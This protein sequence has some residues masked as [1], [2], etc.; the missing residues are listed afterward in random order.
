[1][2]KLYRS[3]ALTPADNS[4]ISNTTYGTTEAD[5][6]NNLRNRINE[7]ESKLQALGLLN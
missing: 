3:A 1:V 5:V 7:L 6:I 4:S 2:I